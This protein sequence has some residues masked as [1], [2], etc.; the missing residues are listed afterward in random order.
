MARRG[1]LMQVLFTGRGTSHPNP[2]TT[3]TD[4]ARVDTNLDKASPHP[5]TSWGPRLRLRRLHGLARA[6]GLHFPAAFLFIARLRRQPMSHQ[7]YMSAA[8]VL[9][10]PRIERNGNLGMT[11]E[12]IPA[13]V[14]RWWPHSRRRLAQQRNTRHPYIFACAA[15]LA[16][17][18]VKPRRAD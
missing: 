9:R 2:L 3:D 18:R 13:S 11:C 4:M 10:R 5:V 1:W 14:V 17:Y 16:P 6:W 15:N 12:R 7:G 8:N